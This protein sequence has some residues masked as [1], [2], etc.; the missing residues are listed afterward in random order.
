MTDKMQFLLTDDVT[1]EWLNEIVEDY[2]DTPH[3]YEPD[4]DFTWPTRDGAVCEYR[5]PRD[6]LDQ[7]MQEK[8]AEINRNR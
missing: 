8:I 5:E 7:V 6:T 4:D 3:L 2:E 1:E